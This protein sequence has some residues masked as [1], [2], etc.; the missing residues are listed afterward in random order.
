L[1]I[2]S[3]NLEPKELVDDAFLRRIPYKIEVTDPTEEEFRDLMRLFSDRFALPY[4]ESMVEYLLDTHYRRIG[5]PLRCCHPRD[6]LQQIIN[7]ASYLEIE[8]QVTREAF[9][10]AVA[11]YFAVL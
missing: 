9:D 1:I 11:N 4:D 3:T 5:R 10:A 7:R 6:L 2:F 8:P